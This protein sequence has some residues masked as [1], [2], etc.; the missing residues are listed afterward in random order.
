MKRTALF[1]RIGAGLCPRPNDSVL[2]R[3]HYALIDAEL[4]RQ[5]ECLGG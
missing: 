4:H 5:L 2:R 3:H 1:S